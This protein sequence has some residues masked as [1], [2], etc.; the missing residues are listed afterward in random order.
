MRLQTKLRSNAWL[1]LKSWRTTIWHW[2]AK[3]WAQGLSEHGGERKRMKLARQSGFVAADWWQESTHGCSRTWN[4]SSPRQLQVWQAE[5]FLSAFWPWKS[6]R[7]AL[8]HQLTSRTPFPLWNKRWTLEWHAQMPVE[9][10]CST[11]WAVSC[12]GREMGSLLW[13]KDLAKLA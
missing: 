7:T 12:P 2:T 1:D 4:H 3:L 5:S 10:L 13:Y 8:W 11:A 9:T 6:T